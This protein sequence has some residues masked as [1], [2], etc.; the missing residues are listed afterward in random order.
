MSPVLTIRLLANFHLTYDGEPITHVKSAPMQSLLAYLL[1]HRDRP[2]A[3]QHLAY[4]LWPDSTEAQARTNLRRELHHLRHALPDAERFLRIDA[5]FLQWRSDAAF[6]LDVADFEAAVADVDQAKDG[7]N[8]AALR[9]TLEKVVTLYVGDLLPSCYDDWIV[10]ER[11]RLSQ[12][13]ADMLERLIQLC[14]RHRDYSLAIRYA[15]RLR[16]Y[17][18]LHE[19]TYRHL[20]RL[21]ALNGDRARGLRIYHLCVTTL[22]RE[23]GVD[24]SPATRETYARLIER[25]SSSSTQS[26]SPATV[27]S[28]GRLVG[29]RPEWDALQTAWHKTAPK[30]T[31]GTSPPCVD[32]RRRRDRQDTAG[33]GTARLGRSARHHHRQDPLLCRGRLTGPRPRG[34]LAA[35]G[36]VPFRAAGVG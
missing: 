33:R 23:L 14:E 4:L 9:A 3:R 2:Q 13:F 25:P 5:K 7:E 31:A 24:P 12:V 29:R 32:Q 27:V 18:P 19:A 15:E 8:T 26:A 30:W 35:R 36:C 21:Y 16:R 17:D 20:M 6:T 10:L 1:I 28:E 22:K 34:R 11:E